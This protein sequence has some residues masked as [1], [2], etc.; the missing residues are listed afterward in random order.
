MALS[1]LNHDTK[2]EG[3]MTK[4]GV[5]ACLFVLVFIMGVIRY[6]TKSNELKLDEFIDTSLI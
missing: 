1:V 6:K 5:T 2:N 3:Y 4:S